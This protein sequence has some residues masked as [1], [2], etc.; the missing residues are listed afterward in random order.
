MVFDFKVFEDHEAKEPDSE[1]L[2]DRLK[3]EETSGNVSVEKKTPKIKPRK[4]G[5][6]IFEFICPKLNFI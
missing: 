3:E 6:D 4:V 1:T 5:W 2:F